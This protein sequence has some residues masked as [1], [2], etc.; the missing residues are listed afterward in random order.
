M[1][2]QA[3][4]DQD[5]VFQV[6][7]GQPSAKADQDL[8]VIVAQRLVPAII[9]TQCDQD[10]VFQ[11]AQRIIPLVQ[12]VGGGYQNC[13]GVPLAFGYLVMQ[14]QPYVEVYT[15]GSEIIEGGISFRIKLDASGN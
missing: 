10:L 15:A 6:T 8:V 1:T 7:Q 9:K 4:C 13:L 2:L 12:L 14:I 11:I 3:Q 5:L